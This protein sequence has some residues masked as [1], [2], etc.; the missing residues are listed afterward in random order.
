MKMAFVSELVNVMIAFV[1]ICA[2]LLKSYKIQT[3]LDH[4]Y[5][6]SHFTFLPSNHAFASHSSRTQLSTTT[7]PTVA[8]FYGRWIIV[9]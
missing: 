1:F 3:V 5:L 9:T 7:L 2:F 4:G 8:I 6:H